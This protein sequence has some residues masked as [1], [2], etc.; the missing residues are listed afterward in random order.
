MP[1]GI[2][3][4]RIPDPCPTARGVADFHTLRIMGHGHEI[5]RGTLNQ[6]VCK[7]VPPCAV[8][9]PPGARPLVR[10]RIEVR[11]GVTADHEREI[12]PTGLE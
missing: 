2:A 7:R 1:R 4:R 6:G 9:A 11:H 12:G 5:D 3:R 8:R 10:V